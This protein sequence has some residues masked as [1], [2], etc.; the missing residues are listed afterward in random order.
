MKHVLETK[1]AINLFTFTRERWYKL[2]LIAYLLIWFLGSF[3]MLAAIGSGRL[4]QG[5]GI[6][7][8]VMHD[9]VCYALAGAIG[10]TL[11]A[12]RIMHLYYDTL[13]ERW[14]LWYLLRPINCAG[15]AV[16]TIV[17]FESGIML[18]QTGNSVH[19]KIG[20]AF[21]IGFGYGKVMDKLESLTETLFNGKSDPPKAPVDNSA[22]QPEN[23]A[24]EEEAKR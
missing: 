14:T 24:Q 12:L 4:K 8:I 7:F 2:V 13:T 17:L 10:G 16:M 20:V 19:S 22:S 11:Y 1:A 9:Y 3:W 6:D 21:L 5:L 15:I 18:L 23:T